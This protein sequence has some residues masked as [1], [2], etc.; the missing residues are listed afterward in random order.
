MNSPGRGRL[1]IQT[2]FTLVE[3]LILIVVLGLGIAGV[4]SVFST[5]TRGSVDPLIQKQMNVLADSMLEEILQTS[6]SKPSGS[7]I[8][9]YLASGDRK[10]F[11][12]V[13]DYNGYQ[14][15]GVFTKS[16]STTSVPG[17]SGYGITLVTVFP[18]TLTG[19]GSTSM[20]GIT[21]AVYGPGGASLSLTGYRGSY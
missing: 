11:D 18:S 2:G 13:D 20:K 17:L 10:N 6:Y 3:L 4:L 14:S 8:P 9:G 21:V 16:D 1:R 15:T 7:T 12:C 19:G 5:T